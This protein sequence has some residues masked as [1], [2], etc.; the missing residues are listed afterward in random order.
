MCSGVY[1]AQKFTR[2]F[3]ETYSIRT[4]HTRLI[5]LSLISCEY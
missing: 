1:D 2:D 5:E 4:V 3:A